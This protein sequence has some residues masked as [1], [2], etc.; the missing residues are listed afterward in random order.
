LPKGREGFYRHLASARILVW[1]ASV[2]RDAELT[3]EAHNY[4]FNRYQKLADYHRQRGHS[5]RASFK[6][7]PTNTTASVAAMGL[8]TL[9]PWACHVPVAGL[10]RMPSAVSVSTDPTL[11]PKR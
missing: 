11:R 7:K 10:Q 3:A 8:H 1:I 6:R 2:G 4:F 5:A 9:Q